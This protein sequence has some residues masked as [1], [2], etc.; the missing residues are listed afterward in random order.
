MRRA[1]FQA[2]QSGL[3]MEVWPLIAVGCAVRQPREPA[4]VLVVAV[5]QSEGDVD[6]HVDADLGSDVRPGWG[7]KGLDAESDVPAEGVLD[8]PSSSDAMVLGGLLAHGQVA[9]PAEADPSDL[10][11]VDHA[12]MA[13]YP[14]DL[15]V[16][17]LRNVHR[18]HR[19]RACLESRF[20]CPA[21]PAVFPSL[22]VGLEYGLGCLGRENAEPVDLLA[23]LPDRLISDLQRPPAFRRH[24]PEVVKEIPRRPCGVGLDVDEP[25][26]RR[27]QC[28]PSTMPELPLL[29]CTFRSH[30]VNITIGVMT[31]RRK[32]PFRFVVWTATSST[33][34]NL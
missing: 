7:Y 28:R 20:P 25:G 22:V 33:M 19:T 23:G 32:S 6:S 3:L 24:C 18:H 31:P 11:N 5:G 17:P 8:Q 27:D 34:L 14:L 10:R 15:Q 30:R 26:L 21:L 1:P 12:P 4:M 16:T 2:Q 29:P 13:M 9:G